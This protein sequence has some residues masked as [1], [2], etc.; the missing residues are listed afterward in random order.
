MS[1]AIERARQR[2]E[3]EERKIEADRKAAADEKLKKLEQKMAST[4]ISDDKVRRWV[5]RWVIRWVIETC[6][7][8]S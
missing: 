5:N 8:T 4:T 6:M 1:A 3:E 2:R 7:L